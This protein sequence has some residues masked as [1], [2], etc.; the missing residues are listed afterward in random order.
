MRIKKIFY[1]G[2]VVL[3]SCSTP[4]ENLCQYVDPFVGT[5]AHGHTYPGA[6]TP[7]GAVQL[8]PDTR[9]MGWDASS[10]YHYNDST[11]LGFSHTHLSGTGCSDLADILFHP[12]SSDSIESPLLFSHNDEKASPGYYCVLLK[13]EG[14]LAEMTATTHCG[15]HRYTYKKDAAEKLL[16]DLKHS[17]DNEVIQYAQVSQS[18]SNEI[19][20]MRCSDGWVKG[21]NIYFV[22]QFSKQIE[23]ISYYKDK[24][25]ID[26][27]GVLDGKDLKVLVSFDKKNNPA[28]VCKVGISSVSYKNAL[29]NLVTETDKLSFDDIRSI[30]EKKWQNKLSSIC[31]T[32]SNKDNLRTFYTALYHAFVV[33]NELNDVCGQYP[34]HNK[35]IDQLSN[36]QKEYSTLSIWDVFRTWS[37][38]MTLV[39]TT[40]VSNV[41]QSMLRIYD[42]TGELP[43]WPLSNGETYCMIGYHSVS[44]ITDAYFKGIRG[45][46]V[47]KALQ[48]MKKSAS[49]NEKGAKYFNDLGFIPSDLSKESV[50]CSL[51]Y[52]YDDW[53]IAQFAK[54]IGHKDDYNSYI[55]RSQYYKNIFD[56]GTKFFR[57]KLSNGKWVSS[58]DPRKLYSD[59]TEATPWQYRFFVPHDVNGL[60]KMFGG[61]ASFADA[62]DSIFIV[63]PTIDPEIP[64]ISGV[65]GQY[66]Q[67]NEPSH[68]FA[69]LY[70]YVG[71][72]WKSQ[73][74]VREILNTMYSD[75]PDGLCGNEDCGQMSAWYVMASLGIYPECPGSNQFVLSSP[76]FEKS[77][78]RLCNGKK[79]IITANDPL[80]NIYIEDVYFNGKKMNSTFISYDQLIQGGNLKF[81]L[82]KQPNKIKDAGLKVPYSYSEN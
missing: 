67:G 70:N 13:S 44:I 45:F 69:F 6:T 27:K 38:L 55:K 10:G 8:S 62:L 18:G 46:D 28:L 4:K 22:V 56:K 54:A 59:Y 40:M 75:K 61:A 26:N 14:I 51:E 41:V 79:L 74:W 23:H 49:E 78:I 42:D 72:S 31:V 50:S 66:V 71:Q 80:K 20:G 32:T 19:R 3:T 37:P 77:V 53:C 21:Q 7:F 73:K 58:F 17:L 76:L 43:I 65:I 48:A 24:L 81:V 33:P 15:I 11:I 5:A 57:P 60:V 34:K 12:V 30:S 82:S 64:D 9:T 2:I 1:I 39:D 68:G 36:G 52:C 25:L 63:P 35:K 47:E 29:D 16:I